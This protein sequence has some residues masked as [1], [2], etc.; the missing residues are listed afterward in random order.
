MTAGGFIQSFTT[1]PNGLNL[2]RPIIL[3]L[4]S[5]SAV[6]WTF[7]T[8]LSAVLSDKFG[9]KP[10]YIF[11]SLIQIITALVLFP[12]IST[13]NY[14]YIMSGLA[15]LSMGIGIT[16]GVQAVFILN[17]SLLLF[18]FQVYPSLMRLVQSLAVRSRH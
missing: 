14:S 15:L 18:A 7:F 1:N 8:W 4:I 17:S 16:Y 6:I 11:G 2:E 13:G 5:I 12:L 9:R 10:V 3:T